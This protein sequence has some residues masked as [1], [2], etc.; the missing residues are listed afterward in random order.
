MDLKPF[1]PVAAPRISSWAQTA[2]E[3][4]AWCSR[5]DAPVPAEVIAEWSAPGDVEAF[6]LVEH[7]DVVAYGELWVDDDEKEVELARLI[8]DPA[9]RGRGV[10]RQLVAR[11]TELAHQRHP[12]A[13]MRVH[14]DNEAARRSYA[15]AGFERVT[16]AEETEWNQGQPV[17][18][19][20]MVRRAD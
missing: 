9:H 2:D 13:V 3:V 15:A 5:T 20:W 1:T 6:L 8:V 12:L 11:L 17:A 18:Y 14:P 19:V 16:R 10:G 7:D 4:L